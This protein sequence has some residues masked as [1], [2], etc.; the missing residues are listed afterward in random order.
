MLEAAVLALKT[1][2]NSAEVVCDV[3]SIRE[4]LYLLPLTLSSLHKAT[5]S[6]SKSES[7]QRTSSPTRTSKLKIYQ[8]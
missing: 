1:W 7:P 4:C 3:I 2:L 6:S 5:T 8:E